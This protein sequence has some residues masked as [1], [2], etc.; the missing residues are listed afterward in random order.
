MKVIVRIKGGLGN[1]LYCYA[2][3]KRLAIKNNAELIIDDVSGFK[4]DYLYQRRYM[5]DRFKIPHRKATSIERLNPF[6][7]V[8][9]GLRKKIQQQKSFENRNYVEQEFNEFD[10]RLL[11]LRI[12]QDVYIDGLWQSEKYFSDVEK[13]IRS[14]LEMKLPLDQKNLSIIKK[15]KEKNSVA[16][17]IRWFEKNTTN[18]NA[19]VQLKYY[20]IA[21]DKM[22]TLLTEPYYFI[23]SDN[24]EKARTSIK[25]PDGRFEFITHNNEEENTIWDFWLMQQCDNFII[26]N[27]TFS[28]WAAWLSKNDKKVV[29]FPRLQHDKKNQWCWDYEG[30]MPNGWHSIIL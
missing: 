11:D 6:E 23:F 8:R 24:P 9:R 16:L 5:L 30:Q 2:A 14:D 19:N 10:S 26:A 12:S 18:S 17:H 4:R 27:S 13:E 21:L 7:R 3:A 15:I 1:Q 29:F 22:E 28:W 20:Q 25:L